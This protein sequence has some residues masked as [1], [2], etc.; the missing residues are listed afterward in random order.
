MKYIEYDGKKLC[1]RS[2]PCCGGDAKLDLHFK[3]FGHVCT[4]VLIKCD[5]CGLGTREVQV[6]PAFSALDIA[7]ALWNRR[8]DES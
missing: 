5:N 3:D 1:A 6:G 7:V 8:V 2:C 4:S